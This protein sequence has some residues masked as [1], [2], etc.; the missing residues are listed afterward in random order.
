MIVTGIGSRETPPDICQE[1][2]KIGRWCK[3]NEVPLRSGHAD[4]AD[5]AFEQ[6]AEDRCIAYIPWPGFNGPARWGAKLVA[7]IHENAVAFTYDFHPAPGR[8][9]PGGLK[10]MNRNAMQVMGDDLKSPSSVIGRASGGTGQALRIAAAHNI[11]V[12]NM[13]LQPKSDDVIN[14]LWVLL[15]LSLVQ[16]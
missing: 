15:G 7:D 1:M 6:G 16:T 14:R 8:L 9:S 13:K 10:L 4:G 12:I 2:F 3:E 5:L 11:E